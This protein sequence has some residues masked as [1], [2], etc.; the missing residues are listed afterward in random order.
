[1]LH[2]HSPID[3]HIALLACPLAM[4]VFGFSLCDVCAAN[5]KLPWALSNEH[6][7]KRS[8]SFIFFFWHEIVWGK[9]SKY[10]I[11]KIHIYNGVSDEQR[12]VFVL[13]YSIRFLSYSGALFATTHV[14]RFV[15]QLF[16][17]HFQFWWRLYFTTNVMPLH[18]MSSN[19]YRASS[20]QNGRAKGEWEKPRGKGKERKRKGEAARKH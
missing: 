7:G 4:R 8:S 10:R 5:R 6:R 17:S 15:S 11:G 12:I 19:Y 1:M 16:L 13:S 20:E 2:T 3:T 9:E 14:L 18:I